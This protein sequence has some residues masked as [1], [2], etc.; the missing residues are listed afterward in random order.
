[1]EINFFVRPLDGSPYSST[2]HPIFFDF[3][4]LY[5]DWG[6]RYDY[7]RAFLQSSSHFNVL[8]LVLCFFRK[9]FPIRRLMRLS[10]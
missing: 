5:K 8:S 6:V 7:L 1:M 10:P 9:S 4:E 3:P 2:F